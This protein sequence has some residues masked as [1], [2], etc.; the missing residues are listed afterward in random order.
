MR[1]F[2]L[3]TEAKEVIDARHEESDEKPFGS[4]KYNYVNPSDGFFFHYY[5]GLLVLHSEENQQY[6]AKVSGVSVPSYIWNSLNGLVQLKDKTITIGK[7]YVGNSLKM[8]SIPDIKTLQKVLRDLKHFGVTKEFLIKG[9]PKNIPKTVGDVLLADDPTDKVLSQQPITMFHGTSLKRWKII[10]KTGLRPG[11][12]TGTYA[13]LVSGYSEHNVYLATTEKIAEFYGKRQAE[14]DYDFRYVIL[15]VDVP[16]PAKLLSDDR[17]VK[18]FSSRN[19]DLPPEEIR[20][21]ASDQHRLSQSGRESG[22][23]AYR[24]IILPK[25]IKLVRIGNMR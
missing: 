21:S 2:E 8:R 22:E 12:T 11:K 17:Y 9:A 3:I 15:Q 7:A 1:Y 18:K 4:G 14:K 6:S 19:E 10:E 25:H 23:F 20:K 13:D 24:G 16:D 5:N